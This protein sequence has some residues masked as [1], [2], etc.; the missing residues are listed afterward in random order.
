MYLAYFYH[1]AMISEDISY[2][3]N[4]SIDYPSVSA[5]AYARTIPENLKAQD[6]KLS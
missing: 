4:P 6:S 5:F 2:P 1:R 3:D